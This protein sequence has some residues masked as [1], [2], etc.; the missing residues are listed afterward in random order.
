MG[1]KDVHTV[2]EGGKGF[3][4]P[5]QDMA[6]MADTRRVA[7]GSLVTAASMRTASASLSSTVSSSLARRA[8]SCLRTSAASQHSVV[9]FT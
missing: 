6:G 7:R 2:R 5:S 9:S 1:M 3:M 8:S 4:G